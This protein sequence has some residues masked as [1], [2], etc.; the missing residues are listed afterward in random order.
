VSIIVNVRPQSE[1]ILTYVWRPL[2]MLTDV[3]FKRYKP[4]KRRSIKTG[5]GMYRDSASYFTNS[6]T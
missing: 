4:K 6:R 5:G 1:N 3:E 2:E